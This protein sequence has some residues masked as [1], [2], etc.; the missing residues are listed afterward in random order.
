[1]TKSDVEFWRDVAP[2]IAVGWMGVFLFCV[3]FLAAWWLVTEHSL[4]RR[5]RV[6]EDRAQRLAHREHRRTIDARVA[7]DREVARL[8]AMFEAP[9]Y[10]RRHTA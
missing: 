2:W 9:A 6:Q 7:E 4:R 5:R 1:M 8:D 3:V 10:R